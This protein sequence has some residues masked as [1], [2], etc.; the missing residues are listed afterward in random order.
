MSPVWKSSFALEIICLYFFVRIVHIKL[1]SKKVLFSNWYCE[2]IGTGIV[3]FQT[4]PSPT[5]NTV[6]MDTTNTAGLLQTELDSFSLW[7]RRNC[8][9]HNASK[10]KEMTIHFHH[11]HPTAPLLLTANNASLSFANSWLFSTNVLLNL[12]SHS[13]KEKKSQTFLWLK[14]EFLIEVYFFF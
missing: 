8:L 13:I 6:I 11:S 1:V 10:T 5:D 12:F 2:S 9:D 7:C 4:I 3:G 14:I